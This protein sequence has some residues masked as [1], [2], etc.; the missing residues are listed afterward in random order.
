MLRSPNEGSESTI[1]QK[2]ATTI[3][4]Q[5]ERI[6]T[7]VNQMIRTEMNESIKRLVDEA[8][9]DFRS[10]IQSEVEDCLRLQ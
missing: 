2:I 8:M 7:E 10:N 1:I 5:M 4:K 9:A 3:S 6:K